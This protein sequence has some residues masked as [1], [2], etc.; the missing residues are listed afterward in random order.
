ELVIE[1]VRCLTTRSGYTGEDGFE[2]S[3]PA[4]AEAIARRLLAHPAVAPAGLG[5][6]DTLRLEAGLPLHG[7]DIGPEVRPAEARLGFGIA[8]ARRPGGARAGGLPGAAVLEAAGK[9][10]RQLVG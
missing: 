10:A 9:P 3:V 8:P 5:A 7:N 1:G 4:Q 2:I 6:R